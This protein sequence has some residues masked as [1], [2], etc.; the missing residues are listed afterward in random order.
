[1]SSKETI[2]QFDLSN[3]FVSTK[4]YARG[5]VEAINDLAPYLSVAE[6][7]SLCFNKLGLKSDNVSEQAYIQAAVEV[8]V[9]AHFARFFPN[10][11]VY[12]EKV[13]PDRKSVV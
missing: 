3:K 1:M 9:C 4:E 10:G 2:L 12:E 11:F 6:R 8:T 7:E 5:L 13:N